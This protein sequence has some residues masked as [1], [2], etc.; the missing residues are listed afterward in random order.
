MSNVRRR[1]ENRSIAKACK[2]CYRTFYA[3]RES[4]K[5]C[6]DSCK[7]RYNREFNCN[8]NWYSHDPNAG[9]VIPAGTVTSWEMPE[10]KVIF[11]GDIENLYQKMSDYLSDIQLQNESTYIENLKPF[12]ESKEWLKSTS[13]IF[14]KTDFIEVLRVSSKEYKLYVWPWDMDNENPFF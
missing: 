8:R 9:R 12:S 10:D 4:A 13:Q 11:R 14:T 3:K 2:F 5:Y 6:S 7:V 1:Y